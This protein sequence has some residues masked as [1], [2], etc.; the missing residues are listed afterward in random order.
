MQPADA[1][2]L[3]KRKAAQTKALETRAKSARAK[4]AKK[5]ASAMSSHALGLDRASVE[6]WMDDNKHMITHLASMCRN[7]LI[8]QDYHN[9]RGCLVPAVLSARLGKRIFTDGGKTWKALK[10]KVG[11]VDLLATVLGKDVADWLTGENPLSHSV[12]VKAVLFMIGVIRPTPLPTGHDHG[13]F[14]GPVAWL[15]EKRL[16]NIGNKI[17]GSVTKEQLDMAT[18]WWVLKTGGDDGENQVIM[19]TAE[20]RTVDVAVV[21]SRATDWIIIDGDD[22]LGARL[23]S[24]TARVDCTLSTVLNDEE[25]PMFNSAFNF[26][27]DE[28]PPGMPPKQQDADDGTSSTSRAALERTPALATAIPLPTDV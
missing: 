26:P 22:F 13:D 9:S 24:A 4:G 1:V 11:A 6:K 25:R 5:A 21:W 23:F 10:P 15:V 19:N 14:F 3:Q 18:D 20:P 8:Q 2:A 7:G 28:F 12:A 27:A 16:R 17:H